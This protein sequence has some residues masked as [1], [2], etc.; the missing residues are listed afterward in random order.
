[1]NR[2][3]RTI[4]SMMLAVCLV[5]GA[6][7]VSTEAAGPYGIQFNQPSMPASLPYG[8]TFK[9]SSGSVISDKSIITNITVKITNANNVAVVTKSCTPN[10]KSVGLVN[11]N[12]GK[13]YLFRTLAAGSYTM[14][15]YVTNK[16]VKDFKVFS[17]PVTIT[18]DGPSI[19][20]HTLPNAKLGTG[21]S[22]V[23]NGTIKSKYNLK[24]VTV[25]IM[26]GS[27]AIY[28]KTVS[29]SSTSY[30]LNNSTIK[31]AIRF[32][33]LKA[34]K[35]SYVVTA[36]DVSGVTTTLISKAFEVFTDVKLSKVPLVSQSTSYTCSDSSAAM[37]LQYLGKNVTEMDFYNKI[38]PT[39]YH[40][41]VWKTAAVMNEYLG[42]SK[43]D[44]YSGGS[45]NQSNYESYIISSLQKGY[46]VI[47]HICVT[48]S[49]KSVVG[50]T[51][52][53]HYVVV[54]GIYT[55]SKGVRRLLIN[56]PWSGKVNAGQTRDLEWDTCFKLIQAGSAN[57]YII[58]GK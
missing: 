40:T 21:N 8:S 6:S 2:K 24:S 28:N 26:N 33:E 18:S 32:S 17:R 9:F 51:T 5:I 27:A 3:L 36:S 39:G 29:V 12:I 31:S 50:Y 52:D 55:D 11:T 58:Y 1:M 54:T 44:Y 19:S 45:T 38:D 35:Y 25:K 37:C 46:P 14:T 4:L 22:Y 20:G 23:P 42:S 16:E 13:E 57:K 15:F 56:D 10:S 48:S 7:P 30:N 41:Y 47:M 49:N 53:G 34:G 43:Y